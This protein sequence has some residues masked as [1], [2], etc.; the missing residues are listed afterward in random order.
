MQRS[1]IL[2]NKKDR[3]WVTVCEWRLFVDRCWIFRCLHMNACMSICVC[4]STDY[5]QVL[6][7]LQRFPLKTFVLWAFL[8]PWIWTKC[9]LAQKETDKVEAI[10]F[11]NWGI[12][13]GNLSWKTFLVLHLAVLIKSDRCGKLKK[14]AGERGVTPG[15]LTSTQL[16]YRCV[17]TGTVGIHKITSPI[18]QCTAPE[19]LSG[20]WEQCCCWRINNLFHH[21]CAG[22]ACDF[23]TLQI[24]ILI[25]R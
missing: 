21:I 12:F 1:S 7:I 16:A 4:R 3:A 9:R 25:I 11:K 2:W 10:S 15:S 13:S 6:V 5:I 14:R 19:S 22:T 8:N 24:L 18:S 17:T 23:L 20:A